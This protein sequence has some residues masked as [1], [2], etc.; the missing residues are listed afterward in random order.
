MVSQSAG[1]CPGLQ[2]R[3]KVFGTLTLDHVCSNPTRGPTIRGDVVILKKIL[4]KEPPKFLST[5][6]IRGGKD[7]K[8]ISVDNFSV[9]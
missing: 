3:K 8:F 5:S 2:S 1:F 7:G 9:Q 4:T 6:G